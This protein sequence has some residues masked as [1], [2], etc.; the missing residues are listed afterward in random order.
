MEIG[1]GDNKVVC[2]YTTTPQDVVW[3]KINDP[4]NWNALTRQE[5]AELF[6]RYYDKPFS[7]ILATSDKLKEKNT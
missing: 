2:I 7:L 5:I 4:S 3:S 6:E 1:I